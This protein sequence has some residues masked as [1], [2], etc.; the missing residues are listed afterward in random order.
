MFPLDMVTD[1]LKMLLYLSIKCKSEAIVHN[2]FYSDLDRG[3]RTHPGE[4]HLF[5]VGDVM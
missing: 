4:K 5:P 3:H 1:W 2:I